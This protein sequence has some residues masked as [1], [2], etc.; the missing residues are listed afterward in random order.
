VTSASEAGEAERP[1]GAAGGPAGPRERLARALADVYLP[2]GA[3]TPDYLAYQLWALPAHVTGWVS[4]GLTTSSLFRAAG[5]GA[6]P[7]GVTA[8]AAA[9]KWLT[10]DGLGAL[11]R[12][13][14]GVRGGREID[15]DPRLWRMAAE[16]AGT[17]GL[18]LEVA[19]AF[20]PGDPAAFVA[21]AGGG[22]FLKALGRGLGRPAFRVV[23][24]HFAASG[25]VGDVAAKEEVWEVTGQLA[26]LS[27]SVAL[28]GALGDAPDAGA[29]A[30]A[31]AA[32]HSA[33][34]LLRFASLRALQLRTLNYK[35]ARI[36]VAAFLDGR[37]V[38][39]VAAA[40]AD[41]HILS[42]E[43]VAQPR[44]RVGCAVQDAVDALAR[45]GGDPE[46]RLREHCEAAARA[47]AR[48]VAVGGGGGRGEVL[49]RDGSG[50][51]DRLRG[52]FH[53]ML[54]ERGGAP[55]GSLADE[56]A[57][58]AERFDAFAAA[59]AAAGWSV[60]DRS[61]ALLAGRERWD[62]P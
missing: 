34:V 8:A 3:L 25:N 52:L 20:F 23:Q 58:A 61:V 12:L 19:S 38:P 60:E 32:V 49:L 54:A 24:T 15:E 6:G 59:A 33:H 50:Q 41:E 39:G 56:Y 62:V 37:P 51:V 45:A 26:G 30:G 16:G 31:W 1:R 2:S 57:A 17:V 21:L 44:A 10:R 18:A 14:V 27:L 9:I 55:A 29:V 11:G 46:A 48:Y 13:A 22:T 43:G 53:C 28:L 7:A 5:G 47:G 42:W 35:R 36:L 4:A 40:G